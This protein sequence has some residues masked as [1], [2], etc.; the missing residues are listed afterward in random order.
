MPV[1]KGAKSVDGETELEYVV[2]VTGDGRAQADD[3]RARPVLTEQHCVAAFDRY[4]QEEVALGR[5]A[6]VKR[7][8]GDR[9]VFVCPAGNKRGSL[10]EAAPVVRGY[11]GPPAS[12]RQ[13]RKAYPLFCGTGR[14]N[15]PPVSTVVSSPSFKVSVERGTSYRTVPECQSGW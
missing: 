1:E 3:E 7:P 6:E 11:R 10:P 2:L 5:Y 15:A 13:P 4:A 14:A 8:F 12:S 9:A